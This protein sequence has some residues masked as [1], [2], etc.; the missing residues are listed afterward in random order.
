MSVLPVSWN[1]EII[2]D[3]SRAIPAW[4]R[5]FHFGDGLFETFRAID[6]SPVFLKDHLERSKQGMERMGI[7]VPE[8]WNEERIAEEIATL[9]ER[10]G[11]SH[12]RVRLS[13]CRSGGGAYTPG[14]DEADRLIE[15]T[16]EVPSRFEIPSQGE[17]VEVFEDMVKHPS[18][19][20]PFKCTAAPLYVLAKRW[21]ARKG[22]DEALILGSNGRV[23]ESA[24]SNIFLIKGG[25]AITAPVSDGC[26]SGVM[27]D[28]TIGILREQGMRLEEESPSIG[29][30]REAEEFL[31]CN[32]VQGIIPVI[33]FRDQRYYKKKAVELTEAL[34][35]RAFN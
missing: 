33:A 5:S 6:R 29:K 3:G 20:S 15:L 8:A 25:T 7:R 2:A 22:Y 26:V 23:I 4:N 19:L 28:R 34:N 10:V 1:G 35:A 21:A 11:T 32:A 12:S 14:T 16:G 24:S 27:R 17:R 18:L 13:V 30:V 9:M 31:L